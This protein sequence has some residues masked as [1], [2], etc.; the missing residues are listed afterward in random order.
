MKQFTI[1]EIIKIIPIDKELRDEL[2]SM[3]DTYSEEKKLAMTQIVWNAFGQVEDALKSY[4]TE[5]VMLEVSEGK[6][7]IETNLE[8]E[9][10]KEVQKELEDRLT[11]KKE[12]QQKLN[13]V[14]T[15][16]EKLIHNQ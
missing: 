6:R 15:Q 9:V 13:D 2:I 16:L 5:R 14:R 4:W 8:D 10:F 11:G 12:D 3:Y 1:Q 7:Q